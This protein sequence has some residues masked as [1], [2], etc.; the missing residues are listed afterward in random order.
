MGKGVRRKVL[1]LAVL[2][3]LVCTSGAPA[4]ILE[5]TELMPG[6]TY[7]REVKMIHGEQVVVHVVVAPKPGSGLYR[8][9][10]VLSNGTITGRE[11]L[12]EMQERLSSQATVVG[13]N[14]D[15]FNI[16]YGY[17]SGIYMRDGV[18]HGRPFGGRSALGIGGDG[19]LRVGRI[20]LS[21]SWSIEGGN[22]AGLGQ[23]NRPVAKSG[24]GLFTPS[25]GTETPH[26]KN[27]IDI[28]V[29]GLPA[30]RPGEEL[31]AEI[32]EVR[33]GGGTAVPE[34][35]AVLQTRGTARRLA[36]AAAPGLSLAVRLALT[37]W[38]DGVADA[39]G[40]G[41]ELVRGG[42]IIVPTD[43]DF[44]SSQLEPRHP[45]T[46]VGQ[47]R[48]GRIVLMAVD[49]RQS[50]SA[51][52]DLRDLARELVRRGVVTGMAFDGGGGTTIAF[53]GRVLN[54]PSDGAERQISDALMVLYYGVYAPPPRFPVLSPNG[55]GV[56]EAQQLAYK[57]VRASKV[58]ARLI[59]PGGRVV[60][61]DKGEKE[62]GVYPIAPEG[63]LRE[64]TWEWI[65]TAVDEDGR[66]SRAERRFSVNNTLGFLK[67]SGETL[68]VTR[69]GGGTLRLSF[70]LAREARVSVIVQD[71]LGRVVRTVLFR[72]HRAAG[73]VSAAWNGRDDHGRA[74]R[75]GTYTVR[76]RA[77]NEIGVA[78]L[79]ATVRVKRGR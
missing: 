12:S 19:L 43:E 11:R 34:D 48:D 73:E 22:R 56:A 66:E 61:S 70:E 4:A 79:A 58:N 13:V 67:L 76:V 68:K 6:V 54:T 62:A 1:L 10:P 64:G 46:A 37:P 17:P 49:G 8:V 59:G 5:R 27:A 16:G 3:A 7:T 55:D 21:A 69:K 28:V 41:P 50:W 75:A 52:V 77:A 24:A 33:R 20:D 47:R 65:V 9:V 14:G 26:A 32:V 30:T 38:W 15:L 53:D 29:S 60:W 57:L 51:G 35:G 74:V 25:W 45:R 2:A 39:I 78:D 40:G 42:K 36:A 71:H 72:V 23:L 44:S 18:L 31:G 63:E